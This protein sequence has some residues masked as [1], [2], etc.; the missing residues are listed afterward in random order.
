MSG[1]FLTAVDL[2]P[3]QT[4]ADMTAY[5]PVGDYASATDL[6]NYQPVSSMT[7]YQEAGDYYSASNPSG[8]ISEVPDTY[9][10]NTDLTIVDNKI[11]EISGVQ[12][13]AGTELEFEYDAADNISAINNSA[14]STTPSQALYAKSPLYAG[15]SGTSSFIGFEASAI[16]LT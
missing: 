2:T 15:V 9:L 3:Y 1:N 4:T 8:F 16:L 6:A 5:Q 11:T 13:S 7:A 12:L 14:I 10:Q